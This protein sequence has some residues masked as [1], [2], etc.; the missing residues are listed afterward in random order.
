MILDVVRTIVAR[1]QRRQHLDLDAQNLIASLLRQPPPYHLEISHTREGLQI[2]RAGAES[3]GERADRYEA[4]LR[5]FIIP[6]PGAEWR[7]VDGIVLWWSFPIVDS[8]YLGTPLDAQF[9]VSVTHFTRLPQPR[10][11]HDR[12]RRHLR[13]GWHPL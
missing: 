5:E 12:P 10:T 6:K 7:Q 2:V 4:M 1:H 3:P 8:P 13:S 9:P 11:P